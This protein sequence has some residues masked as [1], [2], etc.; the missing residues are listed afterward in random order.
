MFRYFR[1]FNQRGNLILMI[2]DNV[3]T[4]PHNTYEKVNAIK[5][6]FIVA[7]DPQG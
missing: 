6:S 4:L 5:L 2:E 1:V 7:K 3:E